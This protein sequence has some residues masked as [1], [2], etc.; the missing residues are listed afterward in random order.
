V[1]TARRKALTAGGDDAK[2]LAALLD[3]HADRAAQ[4][5]AEQQRINTLLAAVP[6]TGAARVQVPLL[7][8]DL[9]DLD[10]LR[11]LGRHLLEPA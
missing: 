5:G 4:A 7:A 3:R 2:L 10:G 1:S 8:E 11:G 9:T 6:A